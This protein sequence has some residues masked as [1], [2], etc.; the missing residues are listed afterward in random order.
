MERLQHKIRNLI[1]DF[2]HPTPESVI[3]M[4]AIVEKR[5]LTEEEVKELLRILNEWEESNL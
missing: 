2:L 3:K 1:Q 4:F 5:Y